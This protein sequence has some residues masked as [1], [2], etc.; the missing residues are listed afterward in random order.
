MPRRSWKST[1]SS[2]GVVLTL[3]CCRANAEIARVRASYELEV[4]TFKAKLH[5][6][7]L[8]VTSLEQSLEAKAKENA[9]LL[10]I[11]DE[12]IGKMDNATAS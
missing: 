6:S 5:R 8:K 12:L 4:S 9:E 7:E 1:S 11:C 10:K 2:D 3:E